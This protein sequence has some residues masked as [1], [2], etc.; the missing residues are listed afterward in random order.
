MRGPRAAALLVLGPLLGAAAGCAPAIDP[1]ARADLDRRLAGLRPSDAAIAAPRSFLPMPLAVGQWTLHRYRDD[2]GL[3]VLVTH[4]LVGEQDGRFWV[5]T[6]TAR[7][8][9]REVVKMLVGGLASHDPSR[10]EIRAVMTRD[11]QG[12]VSAVDANDLPGTYRRLLATLMPGW[13]GQPQEEVAVTAGRFAG[14]YK[15]RTDGEWG[16][17][18]ASSLVG[19]TRRC[20]CPG[21]SAASA[22]TSPRSSSWS[23]TARPV[24][25]ASSVISF[26]ACPGNHVP[27]RPAT[28]PSA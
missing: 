16:Y 22:W 26:T 17:W 25:R 7:Y 1:A 10:I 14:C 21:S 11:A 19:R 8:S 13:E 27:R 12:Q 3:P 2:D 6:V 4:K 20:R 18:R 15:T 28:G 9:G 23:A 24:P 5:E